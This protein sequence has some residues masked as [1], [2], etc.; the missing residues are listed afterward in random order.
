M[1]PISRIDQLD[2]DPER[3]CA[4]LAHMSS[5]VLACL[6]AVQARSVVEVGALAGDLTDVL[7]DWAQGC[8]ARV[9]AVDPS[10]HEDLL[11][12]ARDRPE[13]K[14][15]QKMSI[16]ALAE[17]DL[18]DVVILD[19]DHNY[20]TVISELRVISQRAS[21]ADLPLI[22]FHD[23]CW[24]HARRDDYYDIESIPPEYRHKMVGDRGGL[25]P[26][27][28]GF[29]SDAGLP[30]PKSA[31]R[32]GGPRNGVLTGIEDFIAE[33][34]RLRLAVVPAFYGFG[35]LW[36]QDAPWA[37]GLQTVIEP[38]DANP[39]LAALESNRLEHLARSHSRLMQLARQEA[40]LD[41]LLGSSAFEVAERLSKARA[42]AG[43]ATS[44][45]LVSKDEIRRALG[46]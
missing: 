23:V 8:G 31:E 10:P 20:Y 42:R 41:R 3:N 30:F 36:H 33:S 38:W 32:E 35:V 2:H 7:A 37:S 19:G 13:V 22:L 21:G 43:V 34:D 11:S 45:S 29:S 18:P 39:V 24:P 4:S 46:R 5:L 25:L 9:C 26:Q 44:Q 16:K 1:T 28:P 14:L 12:L 15:V 27:E 6:D 17:I 40:V